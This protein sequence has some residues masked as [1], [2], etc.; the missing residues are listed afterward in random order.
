MKV[1]MACGDGWRNALVVHLTRAIDVFTQAIVQVTSTAACLHFRFVVKFDFRNQQTR[2]ATRIVVQT[3]LFFTD[4]D[5]QLR[6]A[7]TKTARAAQRR[8]VL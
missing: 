2:I 7:D 6:I 3:P 4:I 1:I 8:R 5:R